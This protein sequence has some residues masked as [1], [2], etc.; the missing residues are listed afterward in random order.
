MELPTLGD[1]FDGRVALVTGSSRNLGAAI[2]RRLAGQGATL[3]V[4]YHRDAAEAERVVAEIEGAGG[5]AQA[6]SAD[7]ADGAQVLALGGAVLEQFGRLD[8]LVNTVGPYADTPF[9]TLPEADWDRIVNTN[10]KAAYLLAQVAA[11][12]MRERGWGRI[13]NLCAGSAFV[14][15]HSV[16]GLAKAAV[17]HLTEALAVEL[18][19][20]IT[21][22]AVAPGQIEDTPL[23][24]VIAPGYKDAL[25]D[26]TPLR[27]LVT[28]DELS[29][30]VVL[31]CSSPFAVMT[32]QT[33]VM[34]G[35]W[36]IPVGRATPVI[37]K[38]V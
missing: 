13:V 14:R 33:V 28:W 9:A 6:F 29:Q 1:R 36:S 10:V 4:H 7:A 11:P 31:L 38:A 3:A 15:V 24:D 22:N 8:I 17:R 35:G 5:R 2:A 34:D 18:A 32:G 27:R 37:G 23:I 16:Y 12:R 26:S 19:P 30:L 20:E 21:V 25:R